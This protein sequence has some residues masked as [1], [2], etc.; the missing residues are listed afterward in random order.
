MRSLLLYMC[1]CVCVCVGGGGGCNILLID[2]SHVAML[3]KN[4]LPQKKTRVMALW[5]Q[6][7]HQPIFSSFLMTLMSG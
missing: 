3:G 2:E 6:T 7:A 5:V 1:V 4:T